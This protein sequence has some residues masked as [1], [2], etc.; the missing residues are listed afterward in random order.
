MGNRFIS[1]AIFFVPINAILYD[2]F[3]GRTNQV[4]FM[5]EGA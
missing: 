1:V 2:F 4:H 5:G 3:D